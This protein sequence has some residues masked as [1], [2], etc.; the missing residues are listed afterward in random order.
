MFTFT[1]RP[2]DSAEFTVTA[3]SRDVVTW[4]KTTPGRSFSHLREAAMTDFYGI[5]FVAAKRAGLWDGDRKSFESGV[6]LKIVEDDDE[7]DPTQSAP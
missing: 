6:D 5:A 3:T 2:D 7:P 1:V 4:E